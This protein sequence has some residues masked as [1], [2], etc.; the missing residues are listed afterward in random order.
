MKNQCATCI[1]LNPMYVLSQQVFGIANNM[2]NM[3]WGILTAA[4]VIDLKIWNKIKPKYQQIMLKVSDEIG[5]EYQ[6]NNRQEADN[7]IG[8]MKDYGL[9]VNS[10]TPEQLNE[11][12]TLVESMYPLIRGNIV[13]E[14]I[15]D[16]V[17]KLKDSMPSAKRE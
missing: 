4:L 13:Q 15:F 8:V 14:E 7:A 5:I 1:G 16:R 3:K 11:W 10:L 12:N 9:K 2:L 17:I 6:T